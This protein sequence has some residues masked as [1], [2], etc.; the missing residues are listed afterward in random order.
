MEESIETLKQM[1]SHMENMNLSYHIEQEQFNELE[2][3]I[4]DM[5]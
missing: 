2:N 1:Q 3:Q 5:S 4:M